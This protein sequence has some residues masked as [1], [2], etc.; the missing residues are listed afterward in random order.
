M[1]NQIEEGLCL[2]LTAVT[3]NL[4]LSSMLIF[5]LAEVSNHPM[6][7]LS[8]QYSSIWALLLTNPSLAWSH[9]QKK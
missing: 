9:C 1:G 2:V 6:N 7:P 3:R 5:S 8:L 4:A